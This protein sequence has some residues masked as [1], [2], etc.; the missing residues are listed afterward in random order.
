MNKNLDEKHRDISEHDTETNMNVTNMVIEKHPDCH[1]DD[2]K[3]IIREKRGEIH[4]FSSE[5]VTEIY[6]DAFDKVKIEIPDD[7]TRAD[8]EKCL[9]IEDDDE[10]EITADN[11]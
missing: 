9:N 6:Q 7:T 10:K 3:K 11:K 1:D 8:I 2:K 5:N 4:R